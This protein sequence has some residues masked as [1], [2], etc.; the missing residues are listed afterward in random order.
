MTNV[1]LLFGTHLTS[2]ELWDGLGSVV[3]AGI[4]QVAEVLL[5]EFDERVVTDAAR[6]CQHHALRFVV[7][8][9]VLG[10]VLAGEAPKTTQL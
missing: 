5:G 6:T 3:L 8:L 10:D 7:L 4:F 9:N 1:N 2:G